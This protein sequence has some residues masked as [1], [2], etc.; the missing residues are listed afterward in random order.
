MGPF[1]GEASSVVLLSTEKQKYVWENAMH[2]GIIDPA[3]YAPK[4]E[5]WFHMYEAILHQKL[6]S[7]QPSARTER[8]L[9]A[10]RAALELRQPCSASP[11]VWTMSIIRIRN[12]RHTGHNGNKRRN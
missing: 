12:W 1:W 3:L 5:L 6:C 7:R 10:D 9:S 2:Y 8:T 4:N 11:A